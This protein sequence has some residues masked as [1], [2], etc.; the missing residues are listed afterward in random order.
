ML[1]VSPV[2]GNYFETLGV[3]AAHGRLV[4]ERDD[5]PDAPAVVVLS[6]EGLRRFFDGDPAVVGRLFDVPTDAIR[7]T[8][9]SFEGVS[10]RM[11]LVRELGGVSYYDQTGD[12]QLS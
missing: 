11:Q 5:E 10:H 6:D 7:E 3:T 2:S 8:V 4:T 1:S 12:L 9:R